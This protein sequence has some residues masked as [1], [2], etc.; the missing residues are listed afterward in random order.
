VEPEVK[1]DD[2]TCLVCGT[3]NFARR[4]DCFKRG[5]KAA[6]GTVPAPS[7]SAGGAADAPS[8]EVPKGDEEDEED[9]EG[10]GD[11]GRVA[12]P[13]GLIDDEDG[14]CES[15]APGS[16]IR[17]AVTPWHAVPY[18]EQLAR[19]KKDTDVALRRVRRRLRA[20]LLKMLVKGGK[21]KAEAFGAMPKWCRAC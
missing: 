9:G 14:Q 4:T 7:A 16:D 19:K 8:K 5:C 21:S 13:G 11:T 3:S 18:E 20:Q 10:K 1:P 12:G 17:D 2:W 15:A 6:R